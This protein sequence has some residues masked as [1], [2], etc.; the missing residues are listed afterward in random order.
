MD[1]KKFYRDPIKQHIDAALSNVS[2]AIRNAGFVADL[3]APR[4]RVTKL[5]DKYKDYGTA[6]IRRINTARK[7]K[8]TSKGI[9][10]DFTTDGTYRCEGYAL[11]DY[12]SQ[13][14]RDN[15]DP[16]IKA[17]IDTVQMLTDLILLD[18]ET[19]VAAI[20]ASTTYVTTY[21]TCNVDA[22]FGFWDD[23]LNADSDP[24]AH[25]R[26]MKNVIF[27]ATL[28]APNKILI[29][30]SVALAM[31]GHPKIQE[32]R[33]Y[34]D[35]NLV[36]E[37]GLPPKIEGLTVVEAKCGEDTVNKGQTASLGQIWSDNILVYYSEDNPTLKSLSFMYSPVYE[38]RYVTTFYDPDRKADK[39]EVEECIDE[40]LV[41]ASCAHLLVDVLKP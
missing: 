2:I 40:L 29:P 32:L 12:V 18:R 7:D 4:F 25:I 1:A 9:D 23:Y 27:N 21:K 15:A 38:D 39:I 5:S 22:G 30:Y 16:S 19:R 35:P 3:V 13:K 31:A 20:A 8:D 17:D 33:K 34:T 26:Y 14:D 36:T 28:K 24:L 6:F 10:W 37:G 41:K 11:H